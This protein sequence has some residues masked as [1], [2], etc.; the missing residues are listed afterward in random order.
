MHEKNTF[1]WTLYVEGNLD[2]VVAPD[3]YAVDS[4]KPL[5][6]ECHPHHA[7]AWNVGVTNLAAEVVAIVEMWHCWTC[8]WSCKMLLNLFEAAIHPQDRWASSS[9]VSAGMSH[10]VH[11]NYCVSFSI[12]Y[13]VRWHASRSA[14]FSFVRQKGSNSRLLLVWFMHTTDVLL[15]HPRPSTKGLLQDRLSL[16]LLQPFR[17]T[18]GKQVRRKSAPR[19]SF[20]TKALKRPRRNSST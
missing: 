3:S 11:Q 19:S 2:H 9:Y 12:Q 5:R 18:L 20:P 14:R 10:T 4:H 17:I 15:T 16:P 13:D 8:F 6:L 1:S 7:L